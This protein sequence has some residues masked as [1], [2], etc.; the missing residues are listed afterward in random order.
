MLRKWKELERQEIAKS[1]IFRQI[2]AKRENP[3]NGEVGD[4]DVLEVAHW[5]NVVAVTDDGQLIFVNQYRHGIDDFSLE[6]VAGA[7]HAE[8]DPIVGGQRELMEETGYESLHWR[9]LG[10]IYP[11][12][13]FLT[14]KCFFVLAEN[15][16]KV[17][18]TKFDR[19][20]DLETLLFS[21]SEAKAKL[22]EGKISHALSYIAIQKFLKIRD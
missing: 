22:D 14:N 19:F 5:V 10:E 12:P 8:E 7:L 1:I 21:P 20:E 17:G 13:A 16:R 15:C 18:T 4:F 2:R 3:R 6:V 9:A 11:N